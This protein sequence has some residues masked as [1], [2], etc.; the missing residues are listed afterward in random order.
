ME[1]YPVNR[2]GRRPYNRTCGMGTP[3]ASVQP[4]VHC[5][6]S[7]SPASKSCSCSSFTKEDSMYDHL[8]YL[9]P[10]MAYVPMQT[11]TSVY[12]LNYALSVGTIFPQLCKPFCGKRGVRR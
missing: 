7:C 12:D 10:T 4:Q 1:N 8:Q 9:I 11:F 3:S 5:K 6:D 2:S